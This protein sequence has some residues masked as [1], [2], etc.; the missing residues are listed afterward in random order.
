TFPKPLRPCDGASGDAETPRASSPV[1]DGSTLYTTQW[2][3]PRASGSS[4]IR[5]M[6][7]ASAGAPLHESGGDTFSP[8]HENSRGIA[9]PSGKAVLVRT[10]DEDATGTSV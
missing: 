8:S 7:C 2:T 10:N 3:K 9:P 6:V 5:A 1:A 4:T